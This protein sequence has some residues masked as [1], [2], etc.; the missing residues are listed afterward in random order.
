MLVLKHTVEPS[1]RSTELFKA[2]GALREKQKLGR[3]FEKLGRVFVSQ[4]GPC[5]PIHPL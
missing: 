5:C 1:K 2:F 4:Y 3:V